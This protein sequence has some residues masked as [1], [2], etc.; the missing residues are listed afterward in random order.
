[1]KHQDFFATRPVFTI[2]EFRDAQTNGEPLSTTALNSSLTYYT[3]SGRIKRVRQGLFVTVPVGIRPE[4][5]QVDPFLLAGKMADDALIA[6]QTALA[7]RGKSYS[8]LNS[9]YYCTHKKVKQVCF[10]GAKYIGVQYPKSLVSQQ[11]EDFSTEIVEAHR[12]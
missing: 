1:M 7:F 11:Q 3:K 6:Y 10:Q 4:Q 9:F 2:D 8:L 5:V 12:P